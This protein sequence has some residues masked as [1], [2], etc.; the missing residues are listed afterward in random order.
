MKAI[1]Q[2]VYGPP[3]VLRLG[4]ELVVRGSLTGQAPT[5]DESISLKEN[6]QVVKTIPAPPRSERR[7]EIRHTP[8]KKGQHVYTVELSARDAVPQAAR[9]RSRCPRESTR[10]RARS[11]GKCA[12]TGNAWD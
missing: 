11:S 3:D 9:P 8:K 2:D 5:G 12:S 10:A 6:N 7:F 1:V 4:E